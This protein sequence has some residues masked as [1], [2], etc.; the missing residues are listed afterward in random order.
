MCT[1]ETISSFR[2][3][4]LLWFRLSPARSICVRI[5][6]KRQKI[7]ITTSVQRRSRSQQCK[8]NVQRSFVFAILLS[9]FVV[10]YY[11]AIF[12]FVGYFY[13]AQPNRYTSARTRPKQRRSEKEMRNIE[14]N[15]RRYHSTSLDYFFLSFVH[16]TSSFRGEAIYRIQSVLMSFTNYH[17]HYA[18]RQ[19]ESIELLFLYWTTQIHKLVYGFSFLFF[20]VC[21][22][23]DAMLRLF[24]LLC[25][26]FTILLVPQ[27]NE[28]SKWSSKRKRYH[29][30]NEEL[31]MDVAQS[32]LCVRISWPNDRE[33]EKEWD[34]IMHLN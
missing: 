26:V 30:W 21:F 29:E 15:L 24:R 5:N 25:D 31:T 1:S 3:L 34:L 20:I 10:C 7:C 32:N 19:Y 14:N 13:E 28:T 17:S 4:V 16:F 8:Y 2:H 6:A 27:I 33:K 22:L 11:F 18:Q 12:P 9:P 23:L